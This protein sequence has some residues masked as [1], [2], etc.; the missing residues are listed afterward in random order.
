ML[1]V[2]LATILSI[3]T[4]H[5]QGV[6]IKGELNCHMCPARVTVC[7]GVADVFIL[8]A[9]HSVKPLRR[10]A[11]SK[12]LERATGIE[13]VS[14][15]WKAKVLPLHNARVSPKGLVE[16]RPVVKGQTGVNCVRFERKAMGQG[17][18]LGPSLPC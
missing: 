16:P 5:A 12:F 4:A 15:A 1:I 8:L 3:G 14:L 13:P 18:I 6:L 2:I 10:N 9:S 11:F 7:C 17:W